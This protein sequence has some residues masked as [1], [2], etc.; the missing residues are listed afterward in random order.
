MQIS[1]NDRLPEAGLLVLGD[2]G[3][4]R[5]E[6][7]E[8]ARGRRI[9]IFAVPGAFTPTCHQNH[10]PSFVRNADSIRAGG[11]DEIVCVTVNDPFVADAWSSSTGAG[12]AGV[13]VLADADGSLAKAL[14]MT[15]DVPDAG[16]LTRSLRYSMLVEDGT[17]RILNVEENP[18]VCGIT[19]G[20]TL[21]GQL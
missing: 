9:V 11:V 3:P 17:V 8:I 18:G 10:L 15:L 4:E 20:E 21:L 7:G 6:L 16:L 14:G 19:S 13:R 5:V 1:V 12:D 2:D